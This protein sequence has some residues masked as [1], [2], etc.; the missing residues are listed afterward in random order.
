MVDIL[1]TRTMPKSFTIA[2]KETN[3]RVEA[4]IRQ[5]LGRNFNSSDFEEAQFDLLLLEGLDLGG[6][7]TI[8][9]KIFLE[10]FNQAK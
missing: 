4:I 7:L 10:R 3:S 5:K 6:E 1:S 2:R 8:A 9:D